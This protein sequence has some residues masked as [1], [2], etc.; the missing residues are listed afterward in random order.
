MTIAF[1]TRPGF[2]Q[3]GFKFDIRTNFFRVRIR[4]DENGKL[5]SHEMRQIF[6]DVM[7]KQ[8]NHTKEPYYVFYDGDC[9]FYAKERERV[10]MMGRYQVNLKIFV[11][12]APV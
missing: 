9:M 6:L 1:A 3:Q 5:R 12:F 8:A 4:G 10:D 2:G 7:L 11:F